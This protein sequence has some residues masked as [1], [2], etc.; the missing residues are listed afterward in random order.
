M[1]RFVPGSAWA[2]VAGSR[3]AVLPADTA[4]EQV[5]RVFDALAADEALQEIAQGAD[6]YGAP[7][8]LAD[9]GAEGQLAR[10]SGVPARLDDDDL[11]AN[12][13]AVLVFESVRGSTLLVGDLRAKDDPTFP[14]AHGV[15]RVKALV[16]DL[17]DV[18]LETLLPEDLP[19]PSAPAPGDGSLESG[20]IDSVPGFQR[21]APVP[22]A[23]A[24]PARSDVRPDPAEPPSA[25]LSAPKPSDPPAPVQHPA[26]AVPQDQLGD[27]DGSTIRAEDAAELIARNRAERSAQQ[28]V[29]QEQLLHDSGPLV[30][31]LVCHVGHVNPPSASVCAVC[32][33]TIA[34]G[35]LQR[36]PR[37]DVAVAALPNG[38]R[39]PLHNTVVFGRRPRARSSDPHTRLVEV[40]SP[41]E[42]IS[43]SHVQMRIEDWNV[44]AEDLGSTNGTMLLRH[45][46]QPQ[47]L[48]PDTPTF[49]WPGDQLDIGDG[50][51]IE[52]QA[53]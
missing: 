31:S 53:P 24:N 30:L 18:S 14:I 52:V 50:V 51:V 38:E 34:Q 47:R 45:G 44:V 27:H 10:R 26:A 16:L 7:L 15:T 29:Q 13:S 6:R 20:V 48:R 36:R 41:Q 9:C 28:P 25:P 1:M 2:A 17:A 12:A 32:G 19:E 37:P 3:V 43:R 39:V 22:S 8:A 4:P 46:Q 21:S 23:P 40:E 42:D 5:Q 35:S 33:G 11:E 49:L